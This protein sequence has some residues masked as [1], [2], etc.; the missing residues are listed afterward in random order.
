MK[1]LYCPECADLFSLSAQERHCSCGRSGGRYLDDLHAEVSGAAVPI[2]IDNLS[3]DA[4]LRRQWLADRDREQIEGSIFSAWIMPAAAN[5]IKKR[6][7][8]TDG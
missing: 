1:L 3:F 5:T 8:E 6:R 4:A 7:D 2:G